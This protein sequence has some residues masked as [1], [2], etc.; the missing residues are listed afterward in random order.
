MSLGAT[1]TGR[2]GTHGVGVAI[3]GPDPGLP[4]DDAEVAVFLRRAIRA[5]QL[6]RDLPDAPAH[7]AGSFPL[8]IDYALAKGLAHEAF[9]H[10]AEADGFRSSI[11]AADG[12]FRSGERVGPSHVSI[13]DEPVAGDHA[14]Q[15][16]SSNGIRRERAVV[17]DHGRLR[18]GLSDPWSASEGG[19]RLTGSARA[20]S[21][22]APPLPRM[23]NIRIEVDE[24]V[25]Q[26]EPPEQ[27]SDIHNLIFDWHEEFITI[28]EAL[29]VRAGTT[30]HTAAGWTELSDSPEMAAYRQAIAEGKQVC[31]DF[32]SRLDAT[33]ERGVFTE[34]PW[35]PGEMKEVVERVLGCGWF[36]ENP[37]DVYRY[38][39]ADSAS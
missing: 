16:F 27:I 32:Q 22:R 14:W 11:L 2:D 23:S 35:I 4:W 25:D 33:E 39:P 24:A 5:A 10:A 29:A 21:F 13:V 30:P 7:P 9:G 31:I 26:I 17:V 20:G 15:P 12:R 19:V 36:P 1:S 18:D 38:P 28:E 34:T 8:V 37:E 3:S 6:A